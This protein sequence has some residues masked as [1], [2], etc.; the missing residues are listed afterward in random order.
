MR[1][2]DVLIIDPK[3][4]CGKEMGWDLFVPQFFPTGYLPIVSQPGDAPR[5]WY[6]STTG[7][8]RDE[9]LFAA[10][11]KGRRPSIFVG[12]WNFLLRLYEGPPSWTGAAFGGLIRF[13]GVEI[14]KASKILAE[15]ETVQVR[16]WW[17]AQQPM[18]SDY[19]M[20]LALLDSAGRLVT[21][22]DGPA[23][24]DGTSSPTSQWQPGAYYE[25]VRAIHIPTGTTPGTY[26]LVLAV[27]QWWDGVRLDPEPNPLWALTGADHTY[28]QLATVQ[29]PG[30]F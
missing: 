30:P 17:S 8:L 24:V 7:W 14:Q 26:T 20:S 1:P 3:C 12:P 22:A 23:L 2:G 25:D 5:V 11:Q 19:S 4:A 27:Y 18:T 21:Q 29:V 6:L 10:I 9:A 15:N 28:L 13:N 16:L